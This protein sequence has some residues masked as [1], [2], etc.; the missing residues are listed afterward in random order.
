MLNAILILYH[1]LFPPKAPTIMQHANSF[2]ENSE[3]KVFKLNTEIGFPYGL[4]SLDFKIIVLHYLLFGCWP[5]QLSK[6]FLE[7]LG[8]SNRRY[9]I[10]F[11]QD[12][13]RYRQYRFSFLNHYKIDCVYSMVEP[14]YFKDVYE[15]NS[16]RSQS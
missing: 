16:K 1:H 5:H 9:K 2:K 3:F 14:Q 8:K 7:Y 11:F 4:T 15:N 6:P 12:E 13:Y 10:S